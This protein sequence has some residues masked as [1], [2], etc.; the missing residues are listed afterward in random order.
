M[1]PRGDEQVAVVIRIAVEDRERVFV[2]LHDEPAAVV[3]AGRRA[4]KEAGRIAAGRQLRGRRLFLLVA[5]DVGEPPR[6]P[7]LFVVHRIQSNSA[8]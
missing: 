1:P 5:S 8:G 3:V 6:G 4:A 7:K 2:M